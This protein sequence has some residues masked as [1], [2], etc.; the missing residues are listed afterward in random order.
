MFI[1]KICRH[2]VERIVNVKQ[3]DVK[4]TKAKDD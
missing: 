1:E 3:T 4:A 2:F